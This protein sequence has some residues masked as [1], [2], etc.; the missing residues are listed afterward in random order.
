MV[1][2]YADEWE[3]Y[4]RASAWLNYICAYLNRLLQVMEGDA[5]KR[6]PASKGADPAKRL[7][8]DIVRSSK[9]E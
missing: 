2:C 3:K 9:E 7:R 4:Q 8:I 5:L 6:A 1:E